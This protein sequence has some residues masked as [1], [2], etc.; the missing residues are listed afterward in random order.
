M[1]LNEE[2]FL[3]TI[4]HGGPMTC[5]NGRWLVFQYFQFTY[6]GVL[7]GSVISHSASQIQETCQK[8][9]VISLISAVDVNTRLKHN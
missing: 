5:P 2:Q 8:V 1:I 9:T 4:C 3:A 6:V 7:V